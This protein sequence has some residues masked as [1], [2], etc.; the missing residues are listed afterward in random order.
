MWEAELYRIKGQLL[1]LQGEAESE[2]EACYKK[3]VAVARA[4]E[5]KSFELRAAMSLGRL[6][7]SQGKNKEA[8]EMLDKVY[9][10]F[11]EGFETKDLREAKQLL[12]EL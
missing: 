2:V 9:S 5:A 6:W 7:Q 11:T 1:L 4:Q 8:K 3:A 12:A 10:W